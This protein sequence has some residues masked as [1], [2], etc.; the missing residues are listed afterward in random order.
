VP[1]PPF[2][3]PLTTTAWFFYLSLLPFALLT[4]I[5]TQLADLMGGLVWLESALGIGSTFHLLLPFQKS[6][7]PNDLPAGSAAAQLRNLAL[8]VS[9]A[10]VCNRIA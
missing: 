3:K 10:N 1:G 6:Q 8:L 9:H 2:R 4:L 5:S 7:K